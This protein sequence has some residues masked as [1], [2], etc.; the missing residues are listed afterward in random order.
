VALALQEVED[1]F[2]R[3]IDYDDLPKLEVAPREAIPDD[4]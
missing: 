1:G 2:C 3:L 4:E